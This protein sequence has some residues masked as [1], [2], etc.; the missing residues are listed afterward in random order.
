MN[1]TL[2]P[3]SARTHTSLSIMRLVL[4]TEV[5]LFAKGRRREAMEGRLE[6]TMAVLGR[7]VC[8]CVSLLVHRLVTRLVACIFAIMA[9]TALMCSLV[10]ALVRMRVRVRVH[11]YLYG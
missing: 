2:V 3:V 8:Y 5:C 7:L 4:K 6:Q 10:R 11:M 9:M 1:T